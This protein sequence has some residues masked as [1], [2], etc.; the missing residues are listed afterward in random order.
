[1][2]DG[3]AKRR[4]AA[5]L[6]ADAVGYTRLMAEDEVATLDRIKAYR[7][8]IGIRVREHNGRVVNAPGDNILAEFP[9]ALDAT[10]CAVE[11]QRVLRDR[12]ADLPE[13]RRMAFRIG[14]HLGDVMVEGE[15]IY[16][17]GVNI[18]ARLEGLADPGGICISAAVHEQVR[19]KLGLEYEDLGEHSVKNIS[20]PVHVY[21]IPSDSGAATET[22]TH[23]VASSPEKPSIA[24]LPF[25]NMSGDPEQEYFADGMTEEIIT[26]TS[27]SPQLFVIARNSTFTYKGRPVKVQQ[28]SQELGVQYVV[29]GSI[30]K[31]GNRMR[32][33]AQMIDANTGNHLWSETYDREHSISELF[34]IQDEISGQIAGAVL[35]GHRISETM[36]VRRIAT[37]NL[38]AYDAVWRGKEVYYPRRKKEENAKAREFFLRA[39]ELDPNYSM[40]Y[41]WLSAT[42]RWDFM[43]GW[44]SDP[45]ILD[46]AMGL[47]QQA[48]SLDSF[49]SVAYRQLA[50][51]HML[52]YPLKPTITQI[53]QS[54]A[55][56]SRAVELDT[57]DAEAYITKGIVLNIA[58][59]HEEGMAL[60][61]RSLRLNPHSVSPFDLYHKRLAL[62]LMYR[63]KEAI[64]FY[65]K[66]IL[67]DPTFPFP[68]SELAFNYWTLWITQ[69]E[70]DE[71]ALEYAL[72][73]AQKVVA[74]EDAN[75]VYHSFLGLV[76]LWIK[77]YQK[78]NLE[79]EK[80]IASD[81]IHIDAAWANF[82]MG[83]FLNRTGEHARAAVLLKGA[84][85]Y[86][87]STSEKYRPF[88]LYRSLFLSE[89]GR[90]YRIL[91]RYDDAIATQKYALSLKQDHLDSQLELLILHTMKEQME[92][93]RESVSTISEY[94]AAFSVDLWGKRLPDKDQSLIERDMAALRKAGLK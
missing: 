5:I 91:N 46:H 42:Y 52:I 61:E 51:I 29:E 25:D 20:W 60:I 48:I 90:A 87:P 64:E 55:A 47:A 10:R 9:S 39:I 6:S 82:T 88:T 28:V 62:Q 3:G 11:I 33:T 63:H 38:T 41:A 23:I 50:Y 57:N 43:A 76:Y 37:Q 58:G 8:L 12:N 34:A 83:C 49:N 70:E 85:D 14:I 32:I 59:L 92:M 66:S 74:L 19:S 44:D 79:L 30:R 16:G 80:G 69:R 18:A 53:E 7:D 78:A 15:G 26:R 94:W 73:M 86:L 17:D 45:K 27:K 35:S 67:Q 56:A 81:L 40:A 54:I 24:V 84:L 2:V 72:E 65:R 36:R 4:L 75:P 21:R 93:S 77:E 71:K 22:G 89:L 1:M 31:A 68:Y 13:D